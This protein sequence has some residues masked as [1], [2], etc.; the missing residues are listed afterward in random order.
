MIPFM[1]LWHYFRIRRLHFANRK[2]L[3]AYQVKKLQQFSQQVLANSPWFRRYASQ[4]ITAWP[5]MDKQLMMEHFDVMNTQGLHRDVLM[6]C[7]LGSEQDRDFSRQTGKFSVGLS[8]GTSGQRGL[9][10]VSPQEQQLW[11]GGILA[12]MLPDGVFAG[13]RVAL[14]LRADNNL[15]QSVNNRWLSLA[16]YDL[17]QP[18]QSHAG[19]LEQQSPTII[20][21]PAQVLRALALA[22]MRGEL[23]LTVKKVISVA[24][25]LD[26]QDRQL[27]QQVFGHVG[28]VYQAT[29]GFL[30][31]SCS[32]GTL[33]LNE[34]FLHIEPQWIDERR[35]T[36]V[37]TDFTRQTQPIVRYKLDDVLVVSN[38]PCPCGNPARAIS[39]IEGRWDDQLL[40]PDQQ[41]ILQ[42]IFADL[43]SR[44]LA[45]ALPLT[46][47]YRLIQRGDHHLHL[48]ADC[49]ASELE[50]CRRAM[51]LMLQQQGIETERLCW[52]L[53]AV[54]VIPQ[55]DRKRRRIIR[56]GVAG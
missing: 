18:F 12:K 22:V 2:T 20:V 50:C 16:F 31:A 27:L 45:T 48:M 44:V 30:A 6:A 21:A 42:V 34:E 11:A 14:F 23:H 4:P 28:E 32:H 1:T 15:Y 17:F 35:F 33:H 51:V 54:A 26:E 37:I 56:Q 53:E 24:E 38:K 49:T 10:V 3:E 41:G 13:E 46:A 19:L 29:E 52:Q 47:D 36:P 5:L 9:F 25:V 55:F 39:H 8:S 40:L 43:C 7:A